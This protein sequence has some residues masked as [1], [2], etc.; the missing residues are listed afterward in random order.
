MPSSAFAGADRAIQ[1]RLCRRLWV[2]L[3]SGDG[4][5]GEGLP[6]Y[7]DAKGILRLVR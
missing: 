1:L 5:S 2:A 3:R 6:F 7:A 4:V